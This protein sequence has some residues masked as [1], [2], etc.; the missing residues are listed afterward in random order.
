MTRA[1]FTRSSG[2]VFEDIGFSRDRA[3]NLVLRS[4]LVIALRAYIKH[5]GLTQAEAG[6]RLG[7]TQSRVSE[8]VNGHIDKFTIDKLVIMLARVGRRVTLEVTRPGKSTAKVTVRRQ[9][10]ADTVHV[11][12]KSGSEFVATARPVATTANA[13]TVRRKRKR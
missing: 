3:A 12:E 5:E 2:N 11:R 13:D 10:S 8:L 6:E 4:D 9:R 7:I 1:S